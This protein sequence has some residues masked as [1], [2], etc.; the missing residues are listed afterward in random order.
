MTVVHIQKAKRALRVVCNGEMI[1]DARFALGCCPVGHKQC[2][3]DGRT[4]E[5]EYF[6]CTRNERSKYHLALGLSYPNASDARRGLQAGL[7][8][9]QTFAGIVQ[10]LEAGLRPPWDTPL[11][12][13]IMIHGGGIESDWTAGCIA[14]PNEHMDALWALCP[15]GTRVVIEA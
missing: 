14:L 11:G 13:F 15:L 9:G 5:G 8:D 1:L 2:E 3:G 6:V 7:I 10:R 12:G 4:P